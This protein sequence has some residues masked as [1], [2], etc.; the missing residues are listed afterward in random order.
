MICPVTEYLLSLPMIFLSLL[1]DKEEINVITKT[2]KSSDLFIP[3]TPYGTQYRYPVIQLSQDVV[4]AAGT[5]TCVQCSGMRGGLPLRFT[6]E[7]KIPM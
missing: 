2:I 3:L 4:I 7:I 1:Q 5:S 6:V